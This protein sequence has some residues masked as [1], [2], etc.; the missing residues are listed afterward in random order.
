[1]TEETKM[2]T[3][4]PE[5]SAGV[6]LEQS[7]RQVPD[8]YLECRGIWHKWD[9]VEGMHITEVSEAGH[10]VERHLQCERCSTL[11]RDRFLLRQDRWGI[12]RLEVLHPTYEYP[13][14]Y[15]MAEMRGVDHAKELVRFEQLS[16]TLGGRAAIK[17]AAKKAAPKE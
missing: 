7:L 4:T 17:R 14:G 6:S 5:A 10:T 11:R 3:T 8:T 2:A 15:L 9:L 13:E 1:M 16:R 12:Q